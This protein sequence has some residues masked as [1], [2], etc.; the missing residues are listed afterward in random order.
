MWQNVVEKDRPQMA[1]QH[2]HFARWIP[3]ATDTHSEYPIFIAF[4]QL[5]Q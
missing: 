3:K 1:V 4:P 2:K 5:Q